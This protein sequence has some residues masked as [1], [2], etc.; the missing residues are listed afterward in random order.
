MAG[1]VFQNFRF[2]FRQESGR[3]DASTWRRAAL[4]LAWPFFGGMI[5]THFLLAFA[6]GGFGKSAFVDV[7]IFLIYMFALVYVFIALLVLASFYNLNVKRLRDMGR[8][9]E[10]AVLPLA[11]LLGILPIAGFNVQFPDSLPLWS[12][13]FC[14]VICCAVLIGNIWVLARGETS[15]ASQ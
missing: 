13:P 7:M 9:T 5:L 2:L 15:R 10:L 3:I 4:L 11:A 12:T 14:L 6:A 8:P 1:A